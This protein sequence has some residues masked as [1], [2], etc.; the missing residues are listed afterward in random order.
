MVSAWYWQLTLTTRLIVSGGLE[1]NGFNDSLPY[2][3]DSTK[4][5]HR[6]DKEV[7]TKICLISSS[8]RCLMEMEISMTSLKNREIKKWE[9][10]IMLDSNKLGKTEK[11]RTLIKTDR[12]LDINVLLRNE[13]NRE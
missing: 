11:N 3:I 7:E 2:I 12:T 10:L 5:L 8:P 6:T 9:E 1:E 13:S 4:A